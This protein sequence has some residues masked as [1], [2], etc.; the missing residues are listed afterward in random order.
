[1]SLLNDVVPYVISIG[2]HDMVGPQGGVT[3]RMI[4]S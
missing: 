4:R 3:R 2:N 1:M